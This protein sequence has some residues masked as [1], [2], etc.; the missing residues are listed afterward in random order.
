MFEP[1][2][3]DFLLGPRERRGG[4]VVVGDKS[5]DVLLQ[6]L[7]R[8]ERFATQRLA[9]ENGEP[10][11]DLIEPRRA[12]GGEMEMDLWVLLEPGLAFLVGVEIV[13]DDMQFTIRE[14]LD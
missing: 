11:L 14:G 1:P 10:G 5:I 3:V 13:E 9:L 2:L 6:L 7:D 8:G 4:L 12:S